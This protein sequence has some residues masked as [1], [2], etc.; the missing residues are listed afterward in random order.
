MASLR[1]NLTV[2]K[3]SRS[4]LVT[5]A[6]RLPTNSGIVPSRTGMHPRIFLA[7]ISIFFGQMWNDSFRVSPLYLKILADPKIFTALLRLASRA[8]DNI[9]SRT[10]PGT[11]LKC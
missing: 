4:M 3:R 11:T 1:N 8:D 7:A 2:G 9:D 10:A 6:Q 5:A